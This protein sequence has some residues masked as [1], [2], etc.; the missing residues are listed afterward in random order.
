VRVV[1]APRRKSH[2][3]SATERTA[4]Y[5]RLSLVHKRPSGP[6]N[7]TISHWSINIAAV[8][9]GYVLYSYDLEKFIPMAAAEPTK[10]LYRSRPPPRGAS[11]FVVASSCALAGSPLWAPSLL[12]WLGY[13]AARSTGSTDRPLPRPSVAAQLRAA[14]TGQHQA[15]AIAEASGDLGG[16]LDALREWDRQRAAT[17]RQ[18]GIFFLSLVLAY[19]PV[20]R[21]KAFHQSPAWERLWCEA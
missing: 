11:A 8:P 5:D 19:L 12:G 1:S 2:K 4:K 18:W 17:L 7:T 9:Q 21:W 16:G 20:R 6:L 3:R 10:V 14:V 15:L 13:R